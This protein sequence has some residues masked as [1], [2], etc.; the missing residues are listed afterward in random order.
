YSVGSSDGFTTHKASAAVT[1][2]DLGG[3]NGWVHLAGAYDGTTWRLYRNGTQIA[4]S[5]SAVGA[6]PVNYGECAIGATGMGWADF[7]TG[8]I[9]EAAIYSTALSANTGKAHYYVGVHGAVNLT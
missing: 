7:Y 1:A 2:G 4:S 6:L 9:D 3:A 5:A 8:G